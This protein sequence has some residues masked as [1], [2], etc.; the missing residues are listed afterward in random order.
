MSSPGEIRAESVGVRFRLTHERPLTFKEAAVRLFRQP[1]SVEDL[2]ALRGVSVE[3]GPGE[4]LALLGRNGSGKSTLLRVLGGILDPTEGRAEV[5]GRV[6]PLIEIA[7]GFLPDLSAIENVHLNAALLGLT[8]REAVERSGPVFEFAELARF[9]DVPVRLLSSGMQARL[10]FSLAVHLPAEILLVDEVLA[11]GDLE[12]QARC[13][14]RIAAF[15]REGRTLVLVTHDLE[16][17]ERLCPRALLLEGG[18]PVFSGP[19][20]EA[21]ARARSLPHAPPG[22]AA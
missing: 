8:R 21:A 13:H 10:A 4:A 6:L 2:W 14:E 17:A 5:T 11:V 9:R 15:R 3:L 22:P 1:R 20:R 12:F 7:A 16:T 18:R 19:T